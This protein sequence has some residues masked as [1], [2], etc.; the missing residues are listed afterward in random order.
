MCEHSHCTKGQC[1]VGIFLSVSEINL[2]TLI[3][4]VT[5]TNPEGS[6]DKLSPHEVPRMLTLYSGAAPL[7]IVTASPGLP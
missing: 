4:C 2:M 5:V 1:E 3:V 6:V 7:R